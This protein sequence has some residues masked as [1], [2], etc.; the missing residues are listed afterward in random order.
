MAESCHDHGNCEL[1]DEQEAQVARLEGELVTAQARID[2]R[3]ARVALL[4]GK[5]AEMAAALEW[6]K[7]RAASLACCKGRPDH[8]AAAIVVEL[9][10]D[11][12]KRADAAL[13]GE[14]KAWWEDKLFPHVPNFVAGGCNP[15]CGACAL[16]AMK[17]E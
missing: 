8:Y 13:S 17:G 15:N 12:G 2:I 16:A 5:N 10:A 11:A 1:C 4:Q 7:E 3:D 14:G 6:Y 9:S